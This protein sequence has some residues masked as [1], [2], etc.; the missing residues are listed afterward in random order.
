MSR[1]AIH[2]FLVT[3]LAIA[4]GLILGKFVS[5]GLAMTGV[6]ISS[7]DPLVL[8]LPS[9]V[10]VLVPLAKQQYSNVIAQNTPAQMNSA[11][12]N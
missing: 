11:G 9:S 6:P 2:E 4:V 7:G 10:P 12:G 5:K 3:V 8:A 1:A